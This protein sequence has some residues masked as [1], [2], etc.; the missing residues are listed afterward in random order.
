MRILIAEDDPVFRHLLE[1]TLTKWGYDV[2]LAQNGVEAWD[3][4]MG[5][6]APRIAILDWK[7]PGMEG[8]EICQ[9][10]RNEMPDPFVYII[11]LT[12]QHRDEDLVVG[13]EAGA[14]DYITKP[15]KAEELRVRL[16][17][18]IRI[19]HLIETEHKLT[20][21][22]KKSLSEIKVL[23]GLLPIC[24]Y[25]KKI[26]DDTGYWQKIEDYFS[27]HL[28]TKFTHGFCQDCADKILKETKAD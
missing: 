16:T 19:Q 25:C 28:D 24:A 6:E 23:K 10:L 8:V 15:F 20:E 22:L 26:R 13:M 4:L 18:G 11:L 14:D 1:V 27:E 7:M 5:D 3:R 2:I 17:A 12:S 9:K 21:D